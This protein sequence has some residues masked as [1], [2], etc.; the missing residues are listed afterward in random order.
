MPY[1][2]IQ[3]YTGSIARQQIRLIQQH[4]DLELVGAVVHHQD[5]AGKD[6][7]E[8]LHGKPIGI[9]T[10]GDL[11]VALGLDA[12]VVL[13]NAPFERYDEIIR[14]LAS[15]KNVVTPSA[16]FYPQAR[17][18][19]DDLQAACE[20]G[21]A[22]LLG[23]GVNPGFAGDVLPLVASSLCARVR[24]VEIREL[25]DLRGWDPF[26]LTE[27]MR[28]GR[29]VEEL[30][31]DAE[32]FEFMSNSFQQSCRMLAEALGFEVESV[33]T[34]P[35]FA[36]AKRDLLDGRVKAGSV[37]GI[38]LVVSVTAGGRT[39]VSEDLQWRID[40]DLDPQWPADP[41]AGD[42]QI[43]IDGDPCVRLG[44]SV[45]GSK[46]SSGAGRLATAARMVNSIRDVC[47][48]E[49]GILTAAT[50]PMPRCWNVP[51]G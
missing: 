24:G 49:A 40:K 1:R 9:E 35:S 37:G 5:K 19:F 21:N 26:M 50:A 14:I 15:G 38:R 46:G 12:D 23:T 4:P 29:E 20:Q 18:E 25:G 44:A 45:F 3:W 6:I 51:P 34:E 42:W 32:Y 30:E 11:E 39:V 22:S 28:F 17:P 47:S 43:T 13:Y 8:I 27:V 36:R 31:Q 7:G 48:A 2:V 33:T 10:I 16:A 41:D